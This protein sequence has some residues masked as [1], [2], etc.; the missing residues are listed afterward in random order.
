[1]CF[2]SIMI[3]SVAEYSSLSWRLWSLR[4]CKIS[5]WAFQSL[6]LKMNI[7]IKVKPFTPQIQEIK[8]FFT[9]NT[10]QISP[11]LRGL[12]EDMP[13]PHP[14]ER[15]STTVSVYFSAALSLKVLPWSSCPLKANVLHFHFSR[16]HSSAGGYQ[17]SGQSPLLFL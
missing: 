10:T 17:N 9:S 3:A 7:R 16:K 2:P 11:L 6:A 5:V 4:I 8:H 13:A 14:A 1:M 15:Q 12:S